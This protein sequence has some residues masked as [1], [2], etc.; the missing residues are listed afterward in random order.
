MRNSPALGMSYTRQEIQI[1]IPMFKD[2]VSTKN[3][4]DHT[5]TPKNG[6][7]LVYGNKG[8]SSLTCSA[9]L[10][11]GTYSKPPVLQNHSLPNSTVGC[12]SNSNIYST[13]FGRLNK[14][15]H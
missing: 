12:L 6:K 10:F 11:T 13:Q 1:D 2:R 9:T 4:G 14:L 15:T 8:K 3:G 5:S 7:E